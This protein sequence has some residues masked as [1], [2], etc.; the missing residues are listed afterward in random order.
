MLYFVA[1]VFI[2]LCVLYMGGCQSNFRE[3]FTFAV[4]LCKVGCWMDLK[5]KNKGCWY[6]DEWD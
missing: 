6:D 1:S 5:G 3:P 2:H 4:L